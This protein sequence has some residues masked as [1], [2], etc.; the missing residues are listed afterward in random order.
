M[1]S[2]SVL[3]MPHD[4]TKFLLPLAS[5]LTLSPGGDVKAEYEHLCS[6]I[7]SSERY[8]ITI[9]HVIIR[10]M[11]MLSNNF[12]SVVAG[13]ISEL[14]LRLSGRTVESFA[15]EWLLALPLYHLLSGRIRIGDKSQLD[16]K[17]EWSHYNSKLGLS[18][19]KKKADTE[20]Q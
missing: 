16:Y 17:I 6:Y 13:A 18:N 15:V 2:I 9:V 10:I 4:P 7:P 11:L 3:Y 8:E 1:P 12:R 14:C 19:V 5:M 20:K